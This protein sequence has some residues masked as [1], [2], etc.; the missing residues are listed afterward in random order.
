VTLVLA[1]HKSPAQ[2]TVNGVRYHLNAIAVHLLKPISRALLAQ[3]SSLIAR[4]LG[5]RRLCFGDRNY[6]GIS[7]WKYLLRGI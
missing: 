6:F 5:F 3:P 4:E 7:H 1:G 2:F